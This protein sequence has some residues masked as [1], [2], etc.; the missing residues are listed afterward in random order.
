MK[1]NTRI[2]SDSRTR[3]DLF[4]WN[5]PIADARLRTWFLEHGFEGRIPEDLLRFWRRTGGGDIFET[6]TLLGPF[7]DPAL[8]DDVAGVNASLRQKGLPP[9]FLVF[10]RGSYIG[11]VDL[12]S[13]DFVEMLESGF[14][15]RRR[16]QSFDDWYANTVRAEFAG[17]YG[18]H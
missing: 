16:F 17:R 4:H 5:G 2:L 13:G 7:A 6:E 12:S 11:A 18:L 8:E 15:V 1:D 14:R 10:Y 9:Q 3:P